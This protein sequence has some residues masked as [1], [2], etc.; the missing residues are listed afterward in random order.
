MGNIKIKDHK[1]EFLHKCEQCMACIQYC[2]NKALNYKNVTQKRKR[3]HH[4]EITA[5]EL[6]KNKLEY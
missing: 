3:Y 2:P 5:K 4:P 6:S 1:V